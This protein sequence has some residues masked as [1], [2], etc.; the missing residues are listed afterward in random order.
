MTGDDE[1]LRLRAA[2][3]WA[4]W[5]AS[6]MNLIPDPN[7]IHKMTDE[8]SALAIGRIECHYTL[9][10]FFLEHDNYIL[11]NA[12]RIKDIPVYIVQGRYDIICPMISAWELHKALPQ[13][14]LVIVPDGSHS[15]LDDSM[16]RELVKAT[17]GFK[18]PY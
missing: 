6:I 8:H 2:R 13:S 5:E 16:A 3:T 1:K 18:K 7:A 15:P 17:E 9:N 14:K 11:D 10:K 12:D 4:N